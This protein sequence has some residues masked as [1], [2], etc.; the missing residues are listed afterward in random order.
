MNRI[1]KILIFL[2]ALVAI[3]FVALFIAAYLTPKNN[4]IP[5]W[6]TNLEQIESAKQVWESNE[7]I[8]TNNSPT[9]DDLRPYFSG[10]VTNYLYLTNSELVDPYGGVYTIGR[11]GEPPS[12]LVGGIRKIFP[13]F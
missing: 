7:V 9:W 6:R 11:I 1:A 10:W 4:R 8:K 2:V 12:C 13:K 5:V 3:S